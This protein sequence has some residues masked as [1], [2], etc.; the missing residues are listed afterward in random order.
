MITGPIC[1]KRI[2]PKGATVSES[3]RTLSANP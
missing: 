2:S 3:A 1:S